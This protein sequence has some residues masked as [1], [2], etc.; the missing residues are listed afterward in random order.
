MD[1]ATIRS[2]KNDLIKYLSGLD[3]SFCRRESRRGLLTYVGGQL[4]D[5]PILRQSPESQTMNKDRNG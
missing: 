2:T 5:L 3:D 4:S 1:V